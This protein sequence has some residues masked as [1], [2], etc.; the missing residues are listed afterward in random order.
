M[1]GTE[2][3]LAL[4]KI[5]SR[6]R[7]AVLTTADLG[8]LAGIEGSYLKV[9]LHRAA[10]RGAL[11][12]VERGKYAHPDTH[13]FAVASNILY[14]SYVSFLA[15]LSHHGVTNQ[16]PAAVT[17]VSAKNRRPAF[18]AGLRVDFVSMKPWRIFGYDK[19]V[20]EGRTAFI[21]SLEKA[22][23]DALLLPAHCPLQETWSAVK[24]GLADPSKAAAFAKRMRSTVL[25][26]RVGFLFE[27]SGADLFSLIGR[28]IH[29]KIDRLNPLL[30]FSGP[31]NRRWRIRVNEK[32]LT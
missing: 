7:K 1:E 8:R 30:P 16:M 22:V 29:G 6:S 15:A 3:R 17:V 21:A 14:P 24:S 23:V 13:P 32:D 12:R 26:K 5:A 9:A 25:L 27:A 31:V 10:R 28:D 20:L 2:P 11:V 19:A 4:E 18:A